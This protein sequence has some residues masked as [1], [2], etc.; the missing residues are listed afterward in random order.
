MPV[1][2]V[3]EVSEEEVDNEDWDDPE[4]VDVDELDVDPDEEGIEPDEDDDL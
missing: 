1:G 2:A 3:L 4:D